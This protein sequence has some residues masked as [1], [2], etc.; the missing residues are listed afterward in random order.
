VKRATAK[1]AARAEPRQP[2]RLE[3]EAVAVSLAA[4]ALFTEVALLSYST[5]DPLIANGVRVA[6]WC[7]PVGALLAGALAG[8]LGFAAHVLPLAAVVV[9]IRYLRGLPLRPRWI[10]LAGWSLSLVSLAAGFEI[11]HRALPDTFSASAGG[12][13]GAAV[14]GPLSRAFY[15]AGSSFVLLIAAA[16]GL[17][18]ATGVSLRDASQGARQLAR[19]AT[20][21]LGQLVR[22]FEGQIAGQLQVE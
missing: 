10:P 1:R 19:G 15:L 13:L 4:L 6:N 22:V 14:V 11:L 5:A 21:E 8:S 3:A 20:R 9:A 12:L 7:G 2:G 17:L 16:L 18:A